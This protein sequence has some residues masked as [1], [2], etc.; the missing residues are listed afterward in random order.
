[1]FLKKILSNYDTILEYEFKNAIKL[2]LYIYTTKKGTIGDLVVTFER[3]FMIDFKHN[4]IVILCVRF[5]FFSWF[6]HTELWQMSP[7]PKKRLW[8]SKKKQTKKNVLCQVMAKLT[9][10]RIEFKNIDRPKGVI[11][12]NY[13]YSCPLQQT[14]STIFERFY[15]EFSVPSRNY[16]T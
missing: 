4:T 8:P 6:I 3:K 12:R 13:I 11:S 5:Q 7:Y 9:L 10:N 14:S 2:I 15:I 1:M 16:I